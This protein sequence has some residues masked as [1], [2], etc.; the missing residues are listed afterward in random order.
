MPLVDVCM[1]HAVQGG[2]ACRY[3][4]QVRPPRAAVF[5][6]MAGAGSTHTHSVPSCSAESPGLPAAAVTAS[7]DTRTSTSLRRD[8]SG[9]TS[10][11]KRCRALG[12]HTQAVGGL[13]EEQWKS[14]RQAA[15]CGQMWK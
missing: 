11:A 2:A 6:Y 12:L 10:S 3:G 7:H 4:L 9:N 15:C 1:L 13:I 14:D 5:R 8:S